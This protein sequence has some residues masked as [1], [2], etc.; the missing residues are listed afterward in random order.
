[1]E[2]LW[3]FVRHDPSA[4]ENILVQGMFLARTACNHKKQ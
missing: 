3:I 4:R 2:K 1:M